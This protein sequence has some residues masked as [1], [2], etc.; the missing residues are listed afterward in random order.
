MLKAMAHHIRDEFILDRV[1]PYLVGGVT[2]S[3][4][5]GSTVVRVQAK[6]VWPVGVAPW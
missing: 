4:P 1:V 6:W 3:H 2:A 5:V